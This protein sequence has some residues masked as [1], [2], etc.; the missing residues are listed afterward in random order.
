MK[1]CS[2][3]G[4]CKSLAEFYKHPGGVG[5]R[6]GDCKICVL[7]ARRKRYEDDSATLDARVRAYQQRPEQVAY[8]QTAAYKERVQQYSRRGYL[9]RAYGIT[10][11]DFDRILSVQGGRCA[12]CRTDA[13]ARSWTVDHDHLTGAVRGILCWNCNVGLGHFRDDIVN[14][15]AA[16]DYLI[17]TS[18]PAAVMT[19]AS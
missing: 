13:P 17:R 19:E 7:K 9:E 15:I 18:T 5:G 1:T 14:L 4:E 16:A 3:C 10:L 12:V 2:K 11:D 6:R 8:R